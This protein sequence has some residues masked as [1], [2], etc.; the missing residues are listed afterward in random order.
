[1]SF[2]DASTAADLEP[3]GMVL[4]E[5]HRRAVQCGVA[6]MVVGAAARDI[7]IRHVVGSAPQRATA[8]ID[9]AVAVSSWHDVDCLT[10]ALDQTRA[11]AHRFLVHGV[12]STSSRSAGSSR[13]RAP[14][15]GPTTTRW[16]SSASRRLWP[17][18]FT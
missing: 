6:I 7:L 15:P 1:M 10:G 14:S 17:R 13:L 11:G 4:A 8:D 12:A 2:Y 18:R 5:V 9:I 16:T 3:A